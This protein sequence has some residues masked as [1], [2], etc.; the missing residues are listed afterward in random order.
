MSSVM[1]SPIE[2]AAAGG[3]PDVPPAF[4]VVVKSG[5]VYD[6]GD[7]LRYQAELLS[8]LYPG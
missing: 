2:P 8:R 7:Q 6:F 3:R 4:L 5:P 1:T